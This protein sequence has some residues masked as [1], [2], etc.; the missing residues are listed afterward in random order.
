MEAGL[1]GFELIKISFQNMKETK[2]KITNSKLMEK[3]TLNFFDCVRSRQL[4]TW[5]AYIFG[6]MN[7]ACILY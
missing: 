5:R 3:K 7:N 2:I 6:P 4:F 1:H